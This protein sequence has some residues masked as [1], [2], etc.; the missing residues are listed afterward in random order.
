MS[1]DPLH[2]SKVRPPYPDTLF[3]AIGEALVQQEGRPK[4]LEIGAGD[5]LATGP[6]LE[7]GRPEI[8]AV[9]PNPVFV[10]LLKERFGTAIDIHQG[11]F[12][13]ISWPRQ[14]FDAVYAANSFHWLD[15]GKRFEMCYKALKSKGWLILFWNYY[16]LDSIDIY[17]QVQK[18]YSKYAAPVLGYAVS[19]YKK[20]AT[21]RL[22]VE[23]CA[24]F[25]LKE[26]RRFLQRFAY[27]ADRYIRL[28]RTFPDHGHYPDTFFQE[29][30]NVISTFGGEVLVQVPS[31]LLLAQRR[32]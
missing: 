10:A 26:E 29:I 15:A 17:M 25:E 32:D 12:E 20:M 2:Y 8:H 1:F 27:S 28:L 30:K 24:Y 14:S 13:A 22:L 5:G 4:I 21:R 18:V 19:Q 11:A 7:L 16:L 3:L 23:N 31:Q 6:M 9:E